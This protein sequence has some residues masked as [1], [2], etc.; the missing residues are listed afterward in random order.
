[1]D[2]LTTFTDYLRYEKHHSP[3]TVTA[4]AKDLETFQAYLAEHNLGPLQDARP[5]HIRS[6]MMHLLSQ[7]IMHRSVNRKV[8]ALRRFYKFLQSEDIIRLNPCSAID[9]LRIAKNQPQALDAPAMDLM[10]DRCPYPDDYEGCRDKTILELFY[11]TGMRVSELTNLSDNQVDFGN[12]VIKVLG[13]RSKERIIPISKVLDSVL[14]SYLHRRNSEFGDD[15]NGGPLFLTKKGGRIYTRLVY[16]VVHSHIEMVSTITR[17]SPHVLRHTFASVLLKN[18]ADLL[19]I[20]E[21]LGHTSLAATQVY[22]HTDFEQL[23]KVYKKAHPR[24]E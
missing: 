1:M 17:K 23:T 6:W 5:K 21:L 18:G 15:A 13:K 2:L 7:G 14:K 3:L 10:L 8:A 11:Q 4:Y 20:K 9:S 19:A 12:Q 24:A 22:L 16:R